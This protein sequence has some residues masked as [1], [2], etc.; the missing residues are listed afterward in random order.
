MVVI[1]EEDDDSGD[2]IDEFDDLDAEVKSKQKD[3]AC[4]KH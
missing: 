1:D 2:V 4:N 3:S